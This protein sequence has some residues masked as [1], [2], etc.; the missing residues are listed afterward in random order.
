MKLEEKQ[1]G[2][3][4]YHTLYEPLSL[5]ISLWVHH[6]T[7]AWLL[8]P[9]TGLCGPNTTFLWSLSHT[10]TKVIFPKCKNDSFIFLWKSS[11]HLFTFVK[12]K[13]PLWFFSFLC[14]SL[15][16]PSTAATSS[17]FSILRLLE[18]LAV[19]S[20]LPA[21]C[22][23]CLCPYGLCWMACVPCFTS[24]ACIHPVG[25]SSVSSPP[26]WA[27]VSPLWVATLSYPYL[28]D[29]FLPQRLL[30]FFVS[31]DETINCLA[32]RSVS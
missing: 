5:I 12:F 9:H 10:P 17:F 7:L 8:Q 31:P 28:Y 14:L 22:G 25:L 13:S 24:W 29:A 20:G 30:A 18:A 21:G 1:Y 6:V 23:L 4:T 2:Y 15:Q 27:H 32:A 26:P 11:L 19:T 3:W 16:L